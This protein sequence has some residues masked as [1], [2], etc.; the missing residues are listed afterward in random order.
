[1]PCLQLGFL[2]HLLGAFA[3]SYAYFGEGSGPIHMDG[4]ACSGNESSLYLCSSPPLGSHN[5]AHY[6]DAGVTCQGT[7]LIHIDHPMQI[8]PGFELR[9]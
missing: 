5:C 3:Y 4:V 1:M 6:Q 8:L 7:N 9:Q 2:P